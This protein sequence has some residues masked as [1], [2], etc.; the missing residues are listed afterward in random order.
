MELNFCRQP[1]FTGYKTHTLVSCDAKCPH[2]P[3]GN[4]QGPRLAAQHTNSEAFR[5]TDHN[6]LLGF[7]FSL[8]LLKGIYYQQVY[9]FSIHILHPYNTQEGRTAGGANVF[10]RSGKRRERK[11]YQN[12]YIVRE[13]NQTKRLAAPVDKSLSVILGNQTLY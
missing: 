3:P 8:L 4:W 10:K 1:V 13:Y 2:F 7:R 11:L 5:I 12:S 9:F 6:Q